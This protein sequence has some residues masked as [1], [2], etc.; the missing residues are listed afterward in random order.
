MLIQVKPSVTSTCSGIRVEGV[1][2][3]YVACVEQSI[4]LFEDIVNVLFFVAIKLDYPHVNEN[5]CDGGTIEGDFCLCDTTVVDSVAHSSLPSRNQVLELTVGAFDPTMYDGAGEEYNIV[6]DSSD[7]S[8]YKKASAVS[9]YSTETVFR[10]MKDGSHVF[11]KNVISVV[12]GELT[13][14]PVFSMCSLLR[15]CFA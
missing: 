4:C 15:F 5:A 11:F 2:E 14:Q 12:N 1:L 9:D 13:F 3:R 10:V 6:V 7:V 8:V